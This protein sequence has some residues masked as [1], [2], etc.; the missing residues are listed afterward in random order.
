MVSKDADFVYNSWL[1]ATKD[2]TLVEEGIKAWL[3]V[4]DNMVSKD[5]G[6]VY[7]SWLDA[8]KER[9]L[10]EEGIKAWLALFSEDT[11]SDYIYRAWLEAHGAPALVMGPAI[12]WL[13]ANRDKQEAVF[14]TKFLCK[15]SA[16]PIQAIKNILHWCR[17][18]PDNEDSLW[19]LT[20]LDQ[21]LQ[22]DV[23]EDFCETC[24]TVISKVMTKEHIGHVTNNQVITAIFYLIS[25]SQRTPSIK[26]RT[27]KLLVKWLLY[28]KSYG[29]IQPF[30][31]SQKR[32]YI[33]RVS[34]LLDTGMLD[35]NRDRDAMQRFLIWVNN[36]LPE[37]KEEVRNI[38]TKLSRK[39][40][41]SGLWE[42]VNFR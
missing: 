18:F 41:A 38:V 2:G 28:P 3:A 27:N 35:I 36:W 13:H 11:E 22:R 6:F 42:I 20:G 9:T 4:P 1:D 26:Q 17:A 29:E 7:Q 23:A 8:T 34:E 10:V 31:R 15:Q 19:R 14:V 37:R 5:A 39:Y 33:L 40:P 16:L 21:H 24:E 32:P 12:R 30:P 25:S